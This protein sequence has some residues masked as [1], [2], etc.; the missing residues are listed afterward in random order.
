ML[1]P[2][3]TQFGDYGIF[4]TWYASRGGGTRPVTEVE[5]QRGGK[6]MIRKGMAVLVCTL[7]VL[8]AGCGQAGEKTDEPFKVELEVPDR[9]E[10]GLPFQVQG[11]LV[12]QTDQSVEITH[13]ADLLH[14][15]IR[16]SRGQK[17]VEDGGARQVT[18][19]AVGIMKTL[20][21]GER[22]RFDGSSYMSRNLGEMKIQ[23]PGDYSLEATAIFE[24]EDGDRERKI[25][26]NSEPVWIHVR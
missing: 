1:L 26:V 23:E 17:L 4:Q 24:I 12:N 7:A 18:V 3:I 16:D 14:Y 19:A 22:Y 10:A 5:A 15:R 20:R 2:R 25:E 9:L 21:P 6:P 8:C 13:G 11:V